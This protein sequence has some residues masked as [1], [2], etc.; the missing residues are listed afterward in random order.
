VIH[1]SHIDTYS[2]RFCYK[3]SQKSFLSSLLE[4]AQQF[5]L[6]A[7]FDSN[8]YYS[9]QL[10]SPYY[11]HK[12]DSLLGIKF[13][14]NNRLGITDINS[15]NKQNDW[16][17]SYLSYD[18]KNEFHHLQSSNFDALE[19]D[20][21]FA[22]IP[23]IV[24]FEQKNNIILESLI[25]L[26]ISKFETDVITYYKNINTYKKQE[27][28]SRYSKSEYI[29]TVNK[30]KNHIQ[31]GDIYELNFCQEFYIEDSTIQAWE[32]YKNLSQTSPTPFSVFFKQVDRYL[33]SASPERYLHKENSKIISQPIKGTI[34]KSPNPRIDNQLKDKL[35][36]D[37]KE[38]AENIMIVDLVRNDLSQT[39]VKGSVIVEELCGIYSFE[40]LHQMISTVSSTLKSNKTNFDI[41]KSSFPMGSMTGA[42]KVK[43]M[44]LIEKYEKTKRGLYSG[45]VGYFSP[46]GDFDFNVV[47]RSILYNSTNKYTSFT[48]GSAITIGSD[49]ENE[50]DECILKSKAIRKVL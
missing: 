49:A 27:I 25:E 6:L 5:D 1:F 50:F 13:S 32:T 39:A 20:L 9:K 29:D 45:S 43:A 33:I 35:R 17:M 40:Q 38:Q 36:N 37:I 46:D 24:V 3:I 21:F 28:K 34:H 22:F 11:Y 14:D 31:I 44:E 48:V 26:D 23:D 30:I 18:L 15:I 41:I 7:Y 47:I 4:W 19:F 16:L 2:N 12:Y 8:D 10:K 42:P